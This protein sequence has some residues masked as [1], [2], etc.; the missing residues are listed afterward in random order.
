[1]NYKYLTPPELN[2]KVKLRQIHFRFDKTR[3]F[4]FL[5]FPIGDICSL[6]NNSIKSQIEKDLEFQNKI[7]KT[8]YP[9]EIE[10]PDDYSDLRE[11]QFIDQE[12]HQL[13]SMNSY[14]NQMTAVFIWSLLEQTENK[15]INYIEKIK[16][17]ENHSGFGNWKDR[18]QYF[19]DWNIEL[20][21]L[22]NYNTVLELQKF[23]NKIKHLGKVDSELSKM[24]TFR[25]KLNQP[26]EYITIPIEKYLNS[27]YTYL[28]DL[29]CEIEH[30]FFEYK[31]NEDYK[32]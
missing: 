29:F 5:S 12:A 27:F 28:I 18:K 22:N 1:M 32:N 13:N 15:L 9:T 2:S 10:T 25:N 7:K 19:K 8:P 24:P 17:E 20:H 4:S 11:N 3:I 23:N 30:K 14:L 21:N 16:K 31:L 26:L 6:Y